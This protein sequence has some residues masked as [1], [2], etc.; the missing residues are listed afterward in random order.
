MGL[1]SIDSSSPLIDQSALIHTLIR[2]IQ[3]CNRSVPHEDIVLHVVGLLL[4][5]ARHSDL[6]SIYPIWWDPLAADDDSMTMTSTSSS[7][8]L[9]K[10][11]SLTQLND[12]NN[13]SNRLFCSNNLNLNHNLAEILTGILMRSWRAR[14]GTS[15]DIF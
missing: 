12:S 14:P 2:L 9:Q 10:Y 5:I 4:N 8:L 6:A 13:L 11:H 15:V 7:N 1:Q 3:S